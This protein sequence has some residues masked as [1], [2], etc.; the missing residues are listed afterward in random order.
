[1]DPAL[2]KATEKC[3]ENP[4][5]AMVRNSS[6]LSPLFSRLHEGMLK[7]TICVT[8]SFLKCIS[9]LK[10]KNCKDTKISIKCHPPTLHR[11]CWEGANQSQRTVYLARA[12]ECSAGPGRPLLLI[13]QSFSSV[14]TAAIW[15]TGKSLFVCWHFFSQKIPEFKKTKKQTKTQKPFY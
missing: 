8:H 5:R 13:S 4:L 2:I 15:N 7:P 14:I 11:A 3:T 9:H 6:C 10:Q 12:S 1:M